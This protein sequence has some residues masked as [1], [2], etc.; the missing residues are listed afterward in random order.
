MTPGWRR[1]IE[2]LVIGAGVLAFWPAVLG[3]GGWAYQVCL[4]GIVIA[5]AIL[6]RVRLHRVKQAF[7]KDLDSGSRQ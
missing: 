6:A 5:L 2:N 3:C 1:L 4:L 7:G